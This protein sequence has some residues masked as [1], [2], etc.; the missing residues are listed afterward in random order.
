MYRRSTLR[1][2]DSEFIAFANTVKE[3]CTQH[4]SEWDIDAERLNTLK[5]LVDNANTAYKA[6]ADRAERN[7]ITT[8]NKNKAFDELRRFLSLFIDY[9]E[10]NLSTPDAAIAAMGLRPRRH[11][12]RRPLPPPDEAPVITTVRRHGEI[13]VYV[14]RANLGH[15]NDG[16]KST[17]FFG[18]KLRW[19]FADE[20]VYHV[21]TSTR[22]QYTLRFDRKDETRRI[23]M[24][25]AWINPRLE[26]GPW[27][28]DIEEVAG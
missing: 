13:T 24:S 28:E 3:Q 10:C 15:P 1:K 14:V 9:L 25:A 19:R 27:S 20:T 7:H 8:T 12:S 18:F 4:S 17:N 6:N 22:N 16:L 21:E 2:P 5:T 11:H 26:P 23:V